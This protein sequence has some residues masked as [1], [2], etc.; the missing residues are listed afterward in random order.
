MKLDLIDRTSREDSGVHHPHSTEG[1]NIMIA[2]LLL[3]ALAAAAVVCT[4]IAAAR[5]GYGARP[6]DMSDSMLVRREPSAPV[7]VNRLG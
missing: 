7:T 4:L 6:D 1:T 2:L 3:L 5:D